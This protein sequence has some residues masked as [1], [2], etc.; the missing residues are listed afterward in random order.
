M[1]VAEILDHLDYGPAPEADGEARAWLKKHE[2]GT[3][4]FIGGEWKKAAN[5]TTFETVNPANGEV[6]A[7]VAEAG[8]DDVDVAVKA[9]RKAQGPWSRLPSH[10]RA[11]YLYALA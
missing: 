2:G 8:E 6:L 3:S 1:S 10:E 9:A 4:L 5:G 11:K 7:R